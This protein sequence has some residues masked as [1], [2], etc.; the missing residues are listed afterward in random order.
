MAKVN[1]EHPKKDF[2]H[3]FLYKTTRI[4]YE[5]KFKFSLYLNDTRW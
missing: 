3:F 5:I 1:P 4:M 2:F